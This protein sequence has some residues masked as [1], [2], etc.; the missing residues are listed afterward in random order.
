MNKAWLASAAYPLATARRGIGGI[1][2]KPTEW[3][4]LLNDREGGW[5]DERNMVEGEGRD[6]QQVESH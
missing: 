6:Y 1:V 3:T 5:E 2:Y 4:S